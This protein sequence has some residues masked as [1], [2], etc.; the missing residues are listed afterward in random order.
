MNFFT[1]LK[2]SVRLREDKQIIFRQNVS[3][4]EL[5][6][7]YHAGTLYLRMEPSDATWMGENEIFR[8][9]Q[10]YLCAPLWRG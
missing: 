2:F 6:H 5:E 4:D 10:V 8:D 7:S 1:D 9:V 3:N